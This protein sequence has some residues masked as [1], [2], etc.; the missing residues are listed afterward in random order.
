M[1]EIELLNIMKKILEAK[2]DL[3]PFCEKLIYI[4]Q[5]QHGAICGIRVGVE[6]REQLNMATDEL[7][8]FIAEKPLPVLPEQP[9]EITFPDKAP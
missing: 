7:L 6:S 1:I 3:R 8:K 4:M 9:L 5:K 2:Q